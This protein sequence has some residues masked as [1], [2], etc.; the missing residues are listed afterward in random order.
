MV[1][2]TASPAALEQF[3]V[4]SGEA[5]QR[6]DRYL[7]ARLARLSRT[8]L[9]ELIA[10]GSVR[11]NGAGAKRSHVLRAGERIEVEIRPRPPLSAVAEE[12][13]L[14]VL[15]EDEDIAVVNKPAGMI[16]HSGAGATRGTLVNALLHRFGTLSTAGGSLRP[17]IVHR[18]DKGTSG[19]LV[20]AR[21]DE[22]HRQ[23][24]EQFHE[25]RVAKTYIALVHG[26]LKQDSGVIELPIARDLRRRTRMTA[27][28][29]EG[30]PARTAW[31]VLLRLNGFTLV[32]ADLHTGRTHQLRVHFAALRHPIVGD[33][34]YGAPREVGADK[35]TLPILGRVFL[36][37]ARIRFEH[38][39]RSKAIEARAPL[40]PELR[41]YLGRLA[42]AL[43]VDPQR[44]DAAVRGYL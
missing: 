39:R 22:A 24:A 9:Q 17:G 34:V 43:G 21:N 15:Y 27:R 1:E 32:E 16:V 8:R 35:Q 41:E 30:R 23:L 12:I 31:R 44:V 7:A 38:P 42:A 10:E 5:G 26:R 25:R 37:A 29:R 3:V 19:V 11:V 14:E 4:A 18:I 40:A 2:S 28:R 6:L 13:P 36:H 20:V 33:S